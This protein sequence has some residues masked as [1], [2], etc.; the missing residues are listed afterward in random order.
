MENNPGFPGAVH[1]TGTQ[2]MVSVH[3]STSWV[4][5]QT[6][7]MVHS[8]KEGLCSVA[9]TIVQKSDPEISFKT[10]SLEIDHFLVNVPSPNTCIAN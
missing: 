6:T 9:L 5:L 3:K 8:C 2:S 7:S 10:G 4:L 1:L